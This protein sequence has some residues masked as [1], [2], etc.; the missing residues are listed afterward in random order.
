M[1]RGLVSDGQSKIGNVTGP[2]GTGQGRDGGAVQ[3]LVLQPVEK[4]PMAERFSPSS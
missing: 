1:T 3:R 2:T 4:C